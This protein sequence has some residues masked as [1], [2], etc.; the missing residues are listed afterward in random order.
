MPRCRTVGERA[1]EAQ[2]RGAAGH[3]RAEGCRSRCLS[4]WCCSTLGFLD[5]DG[6]EVCRQIRSSSEVPIIIVT[7]KGPGATACG[8][9]ADDYVVKPF[10]MRE[11]AARSGPMSDAVPRSSV[12]EAR[13][14][15]LDRERH[16][17]HLGGGL[18]LTRRSSTCWL[19]WRKIWPGGAAGEL[20]ARIW[21]PVWVGQVSTST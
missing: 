5:M 12:I 7:A 11:L 14:L 1:R 10:S 15:T 18:T 17:R 9:G 19:C 6:L 8:A 3:N 2:I 21:D 13:T 16:R 20:H 4:T